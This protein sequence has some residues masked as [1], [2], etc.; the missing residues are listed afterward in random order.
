MN[1]LSPV[2]ETRGLGLSLH[3]KK[4][5]DGLNLCLRP[6]TITALQGPSGTGKSTVL[7]AILGT[8]PD[9][10]SARGEVCLDGVDLGTLTKEQQRR[11][12]GR[13]VSLAF[14]NTKASLNPVHTIGFHFREVLSNAGMAS[15]YPAAAQDALTRAGVRKKDALK[16]YPFELSGGQLQRIGLALALCTRPKLLLADEVTTALDVVVQR[17]VLDRLRDQVRETG[18]SVLM[19]THDDFVAHG[20]ADE[21]IHLGACKCPAA[22][23][24]SE[25]IPCPPVVNSHERPVLEARGLGHTY[26]SRHGDSIRAMDNVSLS[27]REGE[28]LAI[29]GRSGSGKSTLLSALGG[30]MVPQ[31]G[32]VFWDGN[33]ITHMSERKRRPL[34][35]LVQMV[36]QIALS[37][38]DPRW[39]VGQIV[40]E[41]LVS[42]GWQ[43]DRAERIFEVLEQVGLNAS[44][45]TRNPATLSGGEQQRVA[46]ARALAPGPRILLCDEPVASLDPGV[47]E[48]IVGLLCDLRTRLGVSI[49]FVT[50]DLTVLPCLCHRVVVISKGRVVENTAVS[51][52]HTS[53]APETRALFP[54]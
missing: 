8:L 19:V 41:P 50:H 26:R 37:T 40:E 14:Q 29:V 36:P 3:G 45:A 10:I 31:E 1:T 46:I 6:G 52:I 35:S 54:L 2:L 9:I 34:R 33:D 32:A 42:L 24:D 38:F 47:R 27:L 44:F 4:L 51:Q 20:W 22:S 39:R 12:R 53:Q 15:E 17:E 25:E 48:K 16:S 7:R 49:L 5:C 43:G 11:T 23:E 30:L 21:I 18:L 28:A 13:V